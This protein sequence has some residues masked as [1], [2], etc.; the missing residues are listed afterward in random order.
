MIWFL[1]LQFVRGIEED[2]CPI[3][4]GQYH[5]ETVFVISPELYKSDKD[6]HEKVEE[7][8]DDASEIYGTYGIHLHLLD[9]II[10]SGHEAEFGTYNSSAEV[11]EWEYYFRSYQVFWWE[12]SKIDYKGR[13]VVDKIKQTDLIVYLQHDS[14]FKL[15]PTGTNSRLVEEEIILRRNNTL[16]LFDFCQQLPFI[17]IPVD[18]FALISN[19]L[20]MLDVEHVDKNCHCSEE[21]D[22]DDEGLVLQKKSCTTHVAPLEGDCLLNVPDEKLLEDGYSTCG[23]L[24]VEAGEECDTIDKCC[25]L[26]CQFKAEEKINDECIS[27][28]LSQLSKNGLSRELIRFRILKHGSTINYYVHHV[29]IIYTLY[30]L[31]LL[32]TQKQSHRKRIKR[33]PK[34]LR[35]KIK[36]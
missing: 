1:L 16:N 36:L 32:I 10:S 29:T 14:V 15:E 31:G 27:Y 4:S 11:T 19:L 34:S 18:S 5:V 33:L 6:V 24:R 7:M 23:N 3:I 20:D 17:Y 28:T 21:D 13:R 12:I 8:F 25:T 30:L 26:N 2:E 35:Q 22:C 9:I